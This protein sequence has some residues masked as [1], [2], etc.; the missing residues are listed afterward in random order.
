MKQDDKTWDDVRHPDPRMGSKT[1][2]NAYF[3]DSPYYNAKP[4]PGTTDLNVPGYPPESDEESE[5][6]T[7]SGSDDDGH[8][9]ETYNPPLP[10][11]VPRYTKA[12]RRASFSSPLSVLWEQAGHIHV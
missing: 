4:L 8:D 3:G 7:P 9:T 1:V 12:T 6:Y 11:S 2:Q 10:T 5:T